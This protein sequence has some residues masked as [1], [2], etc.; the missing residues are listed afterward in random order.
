MS[1][2]VPAEL[3]REVVD[4]LPTGHAF[5]STACAMWITNERAAGRVFTDTRA[6]VEAYRRELAASGEHAADTSAWFGWGDGPAA[7]DDTAL[8][9]IDPD[10]RPTATARDTWA[11]LIDAHEA[12]YDDDSEEDAP[13]RD[14]RWA[15][16]RCDL[17]SGLDVDADEAAAL[18]KVHDSLWHGRWRTAYVYPADLLNS[19]ERDDTA[20]HD[21]AVSDGLDAAAADDEGDGS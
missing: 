5:R 20:T 6:G 10:A 1:P 15:C 11:S 21:A 2:V 14:H 7:V 4:A 16:H 17:T 9:A 3:Y 13:A 12:E 8:F 18:A 19:D